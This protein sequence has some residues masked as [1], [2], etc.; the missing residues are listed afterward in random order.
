MRRRE[1]ISLFGVAAVSWANWFGGIYKDP[2]NFFAQLAIEPE[3]Y[4][5]M[6][7]EIILTPDQKA[8]FDAI[9]ADML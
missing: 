2:Q 1:L 4:L 8:K 6:Y 3:S 7:P 9:H 5:R